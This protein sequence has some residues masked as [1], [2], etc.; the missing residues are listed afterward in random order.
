[1]EPFWP[2]ALWAL[3]GGVPLMARERADVTHPKAQKVLRV[4]KRAPG[5][6]LD[7]ARQSA[8]LGAGSF[9]IHLRNLV[10]A[11]LIVVRRTKDKRRAL[12]YPAGA[13][14]PRR[15][16]PP[17]LGVKARDIARRIAK[18]P[19]LDASEYVE[20]LPFE[21]RKLY[22]HISRLVRDGYLES[23]GEGEG[24]KAL[25]P[26]PKLLRELEDE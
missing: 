20:K 8:E 4:V 21:R 22:Y 23:T 14:V 13:D 17:K 19:G 10:K 1:M 25:Q 7:A 11:R 16:P 18:K 15:L 24:Y 5:T 26:T 6:T 2:G 3:A 9:Y 12:L